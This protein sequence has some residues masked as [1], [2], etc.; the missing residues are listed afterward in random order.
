MIYKTK[1]F[2]LCILS[3]NLLSNNK[4]LPMTEDKHEPYN[5]FVTCDELIEKIYERKWDLDGRPNLFKD[6]VPKCQNGEFPHKWI[7]LKEDVNKYAITKCDVPCTIFQFPL[8]GNAAGNNIGR[9]YENTKIY[10]DSKIKTI[11]GV[12]TYERVYPWYREWYSFTFENQTYY[13][14]AVNIDING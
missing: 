8:M 14:S 10:L 7:E 11:T 5:G 2:F 9:I 12:G 3:L 13:I 4:S 6:G 1:I